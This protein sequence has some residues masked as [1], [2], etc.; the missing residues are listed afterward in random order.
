MAV[1]CKNCRSFFAIPEDADDFEPGKGDCVREEQDDKGKYWK[2]R[3]VMGDKDASKC[4][5]FI[6]RI[7][8]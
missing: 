4:P 1:Y 2:A 6:K 3:P 8:G 7:G 5:G